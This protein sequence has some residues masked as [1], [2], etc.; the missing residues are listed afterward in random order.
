[1]QRHDPLEWM[2]LQ[3]FEILEKAGHMSR[4]RFHFHHSRPQLPAWEPPVD[5]VE[6]YDEL[7]IT[8]VVPGIAF[9]SLEVI[10]EGGMLRI[11]GDRPPP[12]EP[13]TTRIHRLEIPYGRFE[14]RIQLPA[15][16]YELIESRHQLGCLALIFRKRT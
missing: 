6:N 7:Q 8:V 15:G 11:A 4:L 5:I 2:W 13:A 1:M 12:V 9:E 16:R 14:R 3:A 10:L